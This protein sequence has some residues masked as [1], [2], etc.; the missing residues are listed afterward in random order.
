MDPYDLWGLRSKA[1]PPGFLSS[2][3]LCGPCDKEGCPS[4]KTVLDAE[5]PVP[6]PVHPGS[7]PV[8][9]SPSRISEQL[10]PHSRTGAQEREGLALVG[11]EDWG[12]G[13]W[14]HF[15]LGPVRSAA[16]SCL[17][18]HLWWCAPS[19]VRCGRSLHPFLMLH[20]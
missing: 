10:G 16:E 1:D 2:F 20:Q 12:S 18:A 3:T 8:I 15:S 9:T 13:L 19:W 11:R 5:G 4:F 17:E 6:G 7:G 14:K